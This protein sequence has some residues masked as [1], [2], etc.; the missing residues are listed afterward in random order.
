M[1]GIIIFSH[2][3]PQTDDMLSIQWNVGFRQFTNQH[4]TI[5]K[6]VVIFK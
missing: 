6:W 2:F 5:F 4:L 1:L 3:I